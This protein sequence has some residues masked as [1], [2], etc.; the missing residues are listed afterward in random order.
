MIICVGIKFN[1]LSMNTRQDQANRVLIER[2]QA[3]L[4]DINRFEERLAN[5]TTDEKAV[6]ELILHNLRESR[7]ALAS[8]PHIQRYKLITDQQPIRTSI[9]AIRCKTLLRPKFITFLSS[10]SRKTIRRAGNS[11]LAAALSPDGNRLALGL[12]NGNNTVRIR[13]INRQPQIEQNLPQHNPFVRSIAW[14]H[15]GNKLATASEDGTVRIFNT[16]TLTQIGQDILRNV[17]ADLV[18]W[19]HDDD[20]LAI[21]WGDGII[22]IWNTHTQTQ[23]DHILEYEEEITSIA[24]SPDDSKLAT[25]TGDDGI[26]NI[27]DTNSLT[28][29]GHNSSHD[30]HCVA[31]SPD[32][33]KLAI[34]SGYDGSAQILNANTLTEITHTLLPDGV[35]SVAWNPHSTRVAIG[36]DVG[37][38]YIWDIKTNTLI[39][40]MSLEGHIILAAWA[41][42][43]D[44]KFAMVT[45]HKMISIWNMVEQEKTQQFLASLNIDQCNLLRA[46]DM[47]MQQT[48][49]IH[50]TTAQW[51]TLTTFPETIQ[52]ILRLYIKQP[53]AGLTYEEQIAELDRRQQ[54]SASSS[55][56]KRSDDSL[57]QQTKKKTGTQEPM[58]LGN[59]DHDDDDASSD[60]KKRARNS[61]K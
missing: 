31:W 22:S 9:P 60:G 11:I 38:V 36:T 55:T 1:V 6:L 53:A 47:A 25:T 44:T 17:P 56:T 3:L 16:N 42:L 39:H 54:Q 52:R 32:G 46:I 12:F 45:S 8:D 7:D 59:D 13:D 58:D 5:A 30:A 21:G 33:N 27:W 24:W 51:D 26:L 35:K 50:A 18:A 2:W 41:A 43:D 4:S 10:G 48:G 14:S 29:I 28:E 61:K 40:N 57:S 19:S 49:R 20:R 15:D 23:I 37:E 34:G